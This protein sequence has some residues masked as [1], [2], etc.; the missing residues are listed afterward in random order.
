[1]V[2]FMGIL[3]SEVIFM[4]KPIAKMLVIAGIAAV[5][6]GATA[7][8]AFFD[9]SALNGSSENGVQGS[10][11][12]IANEKSAEEENIEIPEE[13]AK[14]VSVA[15]GLDEKAVFTYEIYN[16]I[17]QMSDSIKGECPY[18]LVGK[19]MAEVKEFYPDWQVTEFSAESVTL[20]KN[21]GTNNSERY[22]VGTY[23]G[24]VAVFYENSEEGIYM[25]TEIPVNILEEEKQKML[26]EGIYVEGRERLNRI[27][28]DYSS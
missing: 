17:T 25:L 13:A 6:A 16:D 19:S 12:N 23:E 10:T 26:E 24:Y 21:L 7:G 5:A 11:Q 4:S 28:E 22:V 9:S 1:M 14:E 8:Y 27:L 15:D 2:F 3:C 18:E 20:R